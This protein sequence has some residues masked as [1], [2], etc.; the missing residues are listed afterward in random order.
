M[1]KG[2]PCYS[3]RGLF[4]PIQGLLVFTLMKKSSLKIL[5]IAKHSASRNIFN[6]YSS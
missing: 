6:K 3:W 5:L 1:V 2:E 4:L